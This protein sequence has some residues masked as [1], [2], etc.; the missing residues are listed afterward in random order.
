MQ[1]IESQ[2]CVQRMEIS[3]LKKF[4]FI[5]QAK[6]RNDSKMMALLFFTPTEELAGGNMFSKVSSN[7]SVM[8][9]YLEMIDSEFI[10]LMNQNVQNIAMYVSRNHNIIN[11]VNF[12]FETLTAHGSENLNVQTQSYNQTFGKSQGEVH[13]YQADIS[14]SNVID[15]AFKRGSIFCIKAFV[16]TL[17]ILT[18]EEQFRNCFDKAILL[19]ISRGMDVKD[20]VNSELFYPEIWSKYSLFS[21]IEEAVIIPYPGDIEDLEFAD[22]NI[23]FAEACRDLE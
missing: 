10:G 14:G 21:P 19:M 12:K 17:L 4:T 23:I 18:G 13:M 2:M 3:S 8:Q 20:L 6:S 16:E 15:Y 9:P 22:P 7:F 1:L 11:D 5:G